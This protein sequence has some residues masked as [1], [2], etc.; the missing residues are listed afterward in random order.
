MPVRAA[1]PT[2]VATRLE[3]EYA[4]GFVALGVGEIPLVALYARPLPV[5]PVA[6]S[7]C[8]S[9]LV[10]ERV[11]LREVLRRV[12]VRLCAPA[13]CTRSPKT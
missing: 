6:V 10:P 2:V 1:A 8:R 12:A 3:D 11:S 7:R 9:E 5:R 13:S 4:G